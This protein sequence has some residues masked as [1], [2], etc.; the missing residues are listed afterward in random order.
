M[1][2]LKAGM[3]QDEVRFRMLLNNRFSRKQRCFAA[4]CLCVCVADV[5]VGGPFSTAQQIVWWDIIFQSKCFSVLV[6][7]QTQW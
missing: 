2:I 3:L 6:S 4:N 7:D 5:L 1:P